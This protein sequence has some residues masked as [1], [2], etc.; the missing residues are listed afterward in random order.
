[1]D[2][3]AVL[4]GGGNPGPLTEVDFWAAKVNHIPTTLIMEF[5]VIILIYLSTLTFSLF[6]CF[7]LRTDIELLTDVFFHTDMPRY[8]K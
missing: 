4:K 7:L 3:E 5:S 1:M 2:P 6:V 8:L